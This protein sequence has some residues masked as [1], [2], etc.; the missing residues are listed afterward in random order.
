MKITHID[1]FLVNVPL[2]AKFTTS[3]SSRT[4]QRSVVIE[5]HTDTG[6]TGLGNVDPSPKYSDESAEEIVSCLKDALIPAMLHKDPRNIVL[7]MAEL[8][9]K[10]AGHYHAKA[11]LDMALHDLT[12]KELGIPVYR[13]LGGAVCESIPLVSSWIG[14]VPAQEAADMAIQHVEQGFRTLKIKVGKQIEEDIQRVRAVRKAVG[15]DIQ[16]RIDANEGYTPQQAIRAIKGFTPYGILYCEQPVS[17]DDWH[18][19]AQVRKAVDV[20]VV[21]DEAIVEPKDIIQA[22]EKEAADIVKLKVMKNGGL[23]RTGRMAWLAGVL[24]LKCVLG[25]GFTLGINSLSE[26]HLAASLP[27][28]MMPIETTGMLKVVED[29]ISEPIHVKNGSVRLS[30]APGFGVA[31]D[32]KKLSRFSV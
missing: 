23:Y 1:V 31:L 27:N 10:T 18:G 20:P 19:M 24:G 22:V 6:L 3:Q 15:A 7:C 29:I 11:A 5:V 4:H 32:R 28:I 16:L 14:H 9:R 17:R 21:A 2:R 25:H 30:Q 26:I 13:L 12:A 8:D